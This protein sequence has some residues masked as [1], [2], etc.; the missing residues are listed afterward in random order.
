MPGDLADL[1]DVYEAGPERRTECVELARQ[2]RQKP[3][4]EEYDAVVGEYVAIETEARSARSW[5]PLL[6][7]GL[8]QTAAYAREIFAAG[9]HRFSPQLVDLQLRARLARQ[10][11][12]LGCD[13]PFTLH[14]VIAEQVL[15]RRIGTRDTMKEQLHRLAVLAGWPN[16]TVQVLEEGVGAHPG[17][18]GSFVLLSLPGGADYV[19]FETPPDERVTDKVETV[20]EF[21]RRFECLAALAL[22]P[23]KS[24]A[25]VS[26]ILK[27]L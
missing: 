22:T 8:L 13:P 7:P 20:R 18:C 14:G 27:E 5:Q 15:H 19:F 25:L 17:L 2:A 16:V 23:E 26:E 11:E 4:W 9:Q 10:R 1:L 21:E 12:L 3:W 24:A 6:V